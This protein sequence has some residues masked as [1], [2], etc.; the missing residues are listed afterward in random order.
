MANMD[1]NAAN[2][3]DRLKHALMLEVLSRCLNW[4]SLTYAE[5]HAGAGIYD[6]AKQTQ[7]NKHHITDLEELIE[8]SESISATNPPSGSNYITLLKSWWMAPSNRGKY[9]G[10]VLQAAMFLKKHNK[11]TAINVTEA[12]AKNCKRLTN[13]VNGYDITLKC[14]GFQNEI[15]WLCENDNLVLL[16]DP[17]GIV[18]GVD[19][20]NKRAELLINGDVDLHTLSKV[21]NRLTSKTNVVVLLWT[22]YGRRMMNKQPVE[23]YVKEWNE[24]NR[25]LMRAF[26]DGNNRY[27]YLLGNGL[28]K[29]I[30]YDVWP[31]K[32]LSDC[33]SPH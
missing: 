22:S 32:W 21:L 16:I 31:C 13:A 33:I 26:T 23:D 8:K 1:Q 20:D 29:Q 19:D 25:W 17:W 12:C 28:G 15:D 4:E 10:S 30:V 18:A 14:K 5:T 24:C 6:S 7:L 3:G 2:S 11:T 27:V 9:P